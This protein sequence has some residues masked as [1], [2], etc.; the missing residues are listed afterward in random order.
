MFHLA[1][2]VGFRIC[3]HFVTVYVNYRQMRSYALYG[4][5]SISD[6]EHSEEIA[7]LMLDR[8]HKSN[9]LFRLFQEQS[10]NFIL[11]NAH[12]SEEF[13]VLTKDDLYRVNLG[14]DIRLNRLVRI[15][16]YVAITGRY[17]D[18]S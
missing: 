1:I 14:S 15:M 7:Q 4:I 2:M 5:Q 17:T 10:Q 9:L 3:A 13:L 11:L 8:L 12:E 16:K 6:A 18:K